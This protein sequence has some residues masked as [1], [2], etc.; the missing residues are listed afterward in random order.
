MAPNFGPEIVWG[1]AMPH[2]SY[3]GVRFWEFPVCSTFPA[4][5][6]LL[7]TG[8]G[9]PSIL[10]FI[11]MGATASGWAC[12]FFWVDVVFLLTRSLAVLMTGLSEQRVPDFI[13]KVS[14]LWLIS[15]LVF[16]F[17]F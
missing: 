3:G 9:N 5:A 13:C 8:R 11:Y 17:F 4:S 2:K 7:A 6:S 16:L 12:V 10:G 15:F 1:G 14:I